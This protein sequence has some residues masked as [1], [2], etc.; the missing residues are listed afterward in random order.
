MDFADRIKTIL[1]RGN[2]QD[3][4]KNSEGHNMVI[5]TNDGVK[6]TRGMRAI[7]ELFIIQP[8]QVR[9]FTPVRLCVNSLL[10]NLV[11]Y[12]MKSWFFRLMPQ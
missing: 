4:N 9:K 1:E 5:A 3:K 10:R 8:E 7:M 11:V 2:A 6:K 12:H